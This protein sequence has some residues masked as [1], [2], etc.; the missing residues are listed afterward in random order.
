MKNIAEPI[1]ATPIMLK[2]APRPAPRDP[3]LD[4]FRGLAMFVIL[5]SHSPNN[6]LSQ[7]IPGHFGFSD[8][9]EIFVFCSGMAS[10]IAFGATFDRSGFL[11]GAGRVVLRVWQVYWAHIGMF[12]AILLLL[13][14]LDNTGWLEKPYVDTLNLQAFYKNAPVNI[15]GLFTLTYVPNYFD[16]LP[17]YL[18]ILAMIPLAMLLSKGG[19]GLLFAAVLTTWLAANL[20]YL[21][22]PAEP[23]SHRVWYFNPFAWQL[24]FF[25]GFAFMRGWLP[26]PPVKPALVVAALII[27]AISI[28][29]TYPPLLRSSESLQGLAESL[30]GLN[31]KTNA[32]LLRYAHFLALAYLGWVAAGEG[33]RRLVVNMDTGWIARVWGRFV[34][35]VQKVGQQSLAVFVCS[36]IA[37]RLIGLG[38]DLSG[39]SYFTETVANIAGF[40]TIILVAYVAGWFKSQPWRKAR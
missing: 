1:G 34:S 27:V 7:W 5:V 9:A 40:A 10:A 18:V 36:M 12:F 38:L 28:P 2:A 17:M 3:R 11:L 19:R 35:T 6:W 25:T 23:W 32:G 39:T 30:R 13:T 14:A 37:S 4:F 8:S 22:L 16:I 29:V 31:S 24:V 26:T 20:G 33:G 21:A 15:V